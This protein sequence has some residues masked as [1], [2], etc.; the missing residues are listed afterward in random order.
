LF[1]G[2]AG[3]P[4]PVPPR[5]YW[6]RKFETPEGHL[7]IGQWYDGFAHGASA[8]QASGLRQLVTVPSSLGPVPGPMFGPAH[9]PPP[10][11]PPSK[12]PPPVEEVPLPAA[13]G[14]GGQGVQ[15]AAFAQPMG[16]PAGPNRPV[17]PGRLPEAPM[18][19]IPVALPVTQRLPQAVAQAAQ[20]VN[21][22]PPNGRPPQ[23]IQAA[24]PIQGPSGPVQAPPFQAVPAP[25][26]PQ[27][28][29]NNVPV[30][31][32]PSLQQQERNS[33]RGVELGPWS[34]PR[35]YRHMRDTTPGDNPLFQNRN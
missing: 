30:A 27:P 24:P 21:G 25:V 10:L 15:S 14:V 33:S 29:V 19:N 16:A 13:A 26:P 7:A 9:V 32:L 8:A 35:T 4:P 23:P 6:K 3:N 31:S 11:A 5:R 22:L 12:L 17:G 1:L 2:G 34:G 20:P 18:Y 28:V